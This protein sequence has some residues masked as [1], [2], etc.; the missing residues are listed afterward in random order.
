MLDV[1][2]CCK[3]G[4]GDMGMILELFALYHPLNLRDFIELNI[5]E[6]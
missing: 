4:V 5:M 2:S 3:C 6:A 1:N